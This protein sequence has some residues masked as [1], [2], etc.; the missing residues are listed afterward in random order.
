MLA[1][2]R[3]AN[4]VGAAGADGTACD[5]WRDLSRQTST[6][7]RKLWP[8]L[9]AMLSGESPGLAVVKS[10]MISAGGIDVCDERL[11]ERR[12]ESP[13]ICRLYAPLEEIGRIQ[14]GAGAVCVPFVF[15]QALVGIDVAEG[16]RI[17]RA[18]ARSNSFPDNCRWCSAARGRAGRKSS[19]RRIR[20]RWDASNRTPATRIDSA[21]NSRSRIPV[22][23]CGVARSEAAEGLGVAESVLGVDLHALSVRRSA[24]DGEENRV[25]HAAQD[26]R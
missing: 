15:K 13:P 10:A 4:C 17:A 19:A 18:R 20:R 22:A 21:G 2:R 3:N 12:P 6:A 26:S 8:Q 5:G 7:V 23:T 14:A 1:G 24:R 11:A 25:L 9:I 16:C